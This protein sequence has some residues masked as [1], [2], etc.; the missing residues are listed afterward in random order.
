MI[1]P[2]ATAAEPGDGPGETKRPVTRAECEQL[3][4][5]LVYPHKPPFAGHDTLKPPANMDREALAKIKAAYDTLS[6]NFE[7]SLPVL[8]KHADDERFSYVYEDAGTSCA[9]VKGD[10]GWACCRIIEAHVEVYREHLEY[11]DPSH[12]LRCPS[13]IGD[14]WAEVRR[15]SK[16]R[17]G[18]ALAEL[19]LEAIAWALR[20]EKP[21]YFGSKAEWARALKA[22]KEMAKRIRASG[23]PIAVEHHLDLPQS[24]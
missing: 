18:K 1:A 3:V 16:G 13:F 19:Q 2:L 8:V 12:I 5:R 10:V 17:Q 20:Q 24:Y 22:V 14:K 6:D 21:R 15:W 11:E 7:V 4:A 23:E 9:F